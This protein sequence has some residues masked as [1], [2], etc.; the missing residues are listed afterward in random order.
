MV[1]VPALIGLGS[2]LWLAAMEDVH[3]RE[4]TGGNVVGEMSKEHATP[5]SS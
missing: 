3:R 4:D 1:V 5:L 2:L